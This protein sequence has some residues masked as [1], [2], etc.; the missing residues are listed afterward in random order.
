VNRAPHYSRSSD[1]HSCTSNIEL[2]KSHNRAIDTRCIRHFAFSALRELGK[3]HLQ[4]GDV[5]G[6]GIASLAN[7]IANQKR[8]RNSAQ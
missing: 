7:S 5:A 8:Q 4:S 6:T 3:P 2:P 1:A